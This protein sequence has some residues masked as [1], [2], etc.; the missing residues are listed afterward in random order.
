MNVSEMAV[1]HIEKLP[2]RAVGLT[3]AKGLNRSNVEG[4]RVP[5]QVDQDRFANAEVPN[6]V[7]VCVRIERHGTEMWRREGAK[8][9]VR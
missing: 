7:D 9:V 4:G 1:D 5:V 2:V 6:A 3:L 8:P